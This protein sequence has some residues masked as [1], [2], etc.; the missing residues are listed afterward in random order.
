[1]RFLEVELELELLSGP[2]LANAQFLP[3]AVIAAAQRGIGGSFN[4][5]SSKRCG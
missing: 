3:L 1:M 4:L 2:S 5:R